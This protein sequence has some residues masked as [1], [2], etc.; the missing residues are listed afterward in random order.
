MTLIALLTAGLML[1]G[2]VTLKDQ[3]ADADGRITLGDLFEGAGSA[4]SVVVAVRAGPS[5]VL[6]AGQLQG[7]AARAGL[8]WSNPDGLR[9]VVVRQG[10]D[11]PPE[12]RGR[13]AQLAGGRQAAT[14]EILTYA[15]S[16]AAGDIVGPE[17]VVFA[18]VQ[19]HQAPSGAPQEAE[20]VIGLTARRPVRAGAAVQ[21]ADLASPKVIARNDAVQVTYQTGGVTLTV[22]GRAQRDATRGEPLTILN[23][24]SGKTIEAVATGPGRAIAGPAALNARQSSISVR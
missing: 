7:Q 23:T 2:P 8:Q 19:A 14:V 5:A 24:A 22:T 3:P 20:A 16:L 11:L 1:N 10:F 6:D 4:S 17:D 21:R 9:R 15:R 18:P 13:P 12:G